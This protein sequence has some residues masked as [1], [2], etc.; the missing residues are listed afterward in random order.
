M[1]LKIHI[2]EAGYDGGSI[3]ADCELEVDRKEIVALLGR[4]GVGKTTLMRAAMGLLPKTRGAVVLNG[5][6]IIAFPPA[7]RARLGI[8]YVPQGREIFSRL[9]VLENLR[10]SAIAT[11]HDNPQDVGEVLKYFPI[12][13]ERASDLAANLSGGQQQLLSI[14]RALVTKPG[15]LLL[16]EPTE[17]LQPSLVDQIEDLLKTNV[18]SGM[19]ILVAEQNLDFALR[20]ASRIYVMDKGS[21]VRRL[22]HWEAKE[23]KNLLHE[24]LGV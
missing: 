17:G 3:L 10:V 9:T 19:G 5:N 2:R 23:D 16:D 22:D 15:T 13:R 12:L 21:I 20:I 24:L 6:E 7:R 11:N 18:G 8:A 4:N 1:L 14:A